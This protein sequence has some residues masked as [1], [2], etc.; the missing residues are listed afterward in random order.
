MIVPRASS[1]QGHLRRILCSSEIIVLVWQTSAIHS[2]QVHC[3][4]AH[5]ADRSET[6]RVSWVVSLIITAIY[7]GKLS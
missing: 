7:Y 4:M 2:R 3:T 5:I 1:S 6:G